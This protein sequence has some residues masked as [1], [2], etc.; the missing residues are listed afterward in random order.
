MKVKS[1]LGQYELQVDGLQKEN[2]DLKRRLGES[3][4]RLGQL[5]QELEK[6]GNGLRNKT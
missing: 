1:S 3:E 6:V 2:Y 5:S 4:S